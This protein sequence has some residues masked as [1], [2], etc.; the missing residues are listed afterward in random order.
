M[1]AILLINSTKKEQKRKEIWIMRKR[2]LHFHMYAFLGFKYTKHI[3]EYPDPSGKKE[4]IPKRKKYW[5]SFE[6]KVPNYVMP[7]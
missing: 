1:L 5:T 2:N 3:D 7:T 6:C 4:N